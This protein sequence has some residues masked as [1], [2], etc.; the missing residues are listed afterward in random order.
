[1]K[2]TLK[3]R[4]GLIEKKNQFELASTIIDLL[5]SSEINSIELVGSLS[6]NKIDKYSDI[7]F[8]LKDTNSSP[9]DNINIALGIIQDNFEVVFFDWAK[10]LLPE[11]Y[12][13]SVFL[14]QNNIFW[15]VDLTCCRDAKYSNVNRDLLP[16]DKIYHIFK[17]WICNAKQQIRKREER[18]HIDIVYQRIFTD[19]KIS[20]KEKYAKILD[21]LSKNSNDEY[22]LNKCSQIMKKINKG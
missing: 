12:V 16:Q 18:N 20:N 11:K 6:E 21:W 14:K 17:L 1:M 8:M 2:G 7:D 19:I 5:R 4:N 9:L 10:S 13:F 15:F 3:K 22:L